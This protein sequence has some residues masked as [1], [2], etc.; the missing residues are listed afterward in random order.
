MLESLIGVILIFFHL[1]LVAIIVFAIDSIRGSRLC[2]VGILPPKHGAYLHLV[3]GF[4]I[5]FAMT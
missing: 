3:V 2:V 1:V 5:R 4:L